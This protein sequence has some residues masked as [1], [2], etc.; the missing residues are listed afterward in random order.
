ML[1]ISAICL[2]S[3]VSAFG[4]RVHDNMKNVLNWPQHG[5]QELILLQ[6]DQLLGLYPHVEWCTWV[7]AITE[8]WWFKTIPITR[9][10]ENKSLTINRI[11]FEIIMLNLHPK[12]RC[13]HLYFILRV[14]G[15]KQGMGRSTHYRDLPI[16]ITK[17]KEYWTITASGAIFC[18]FSMQCAQHI[19]PAIGQLHN[20][21]QEQKQPAFL[22]LLL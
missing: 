8:L 9:K 15:I 3:S 11:P 4:S 6:W 17:S 19:F 1:I 7:Q 10:W 12:C 18:M 21:S 14:F 2:W 5:S 20:L 22:E 16:Q 13:R